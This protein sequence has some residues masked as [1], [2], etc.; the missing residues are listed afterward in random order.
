M[1]ENSNSSRLARI[2]SHGK[3]NS[4]NMQPDVKTAPVVKEQKMKFEGFDKFKRDLQ[5][6]F[7][8][9]GG[10]VPLPELFHPEFMRQHTKFATLQE[11]VDASGLFENTPNEEAKA[12]FDGDAGG[13]LWPR[14]RITRHGRK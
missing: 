12:I 7:D 4:A 1:V 3:S 10:K 13:S 9:F 2:D 14:T 8:K 6:K 11:M 5:R